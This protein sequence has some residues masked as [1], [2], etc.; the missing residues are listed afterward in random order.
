MAINKQYIRREGIQN[1]HTVGGQDSTTNIYRTEFSGPETNQVVVLAL[2]RGATIAGDITAKPPAD[3]GQFS[4]ATAFYLFAKT[5]ITT[6]VNDNLTTWDTVVTYVEPGP[7]DD[8]SQLQANPLLRPPVFNVEFIETEYPIEQARNLVALP[9]GAA[10]GSNRAVDTLGD[11][12]NAAGK[13]PDEPQMDTERNAVLI[14]ERNYPTLANIVAVNEQFKRSTNSDVVEGFAVETLQYMVTDSQG[15][16]IEGE[17]TYFPG[18]TRI[19][20]KKTTKRIISN[21]GYAFWDDDA[22]KF[23]PGRKEV[24]FEFGPPQIEFQPEI[25]EEWVPIPGGGVWEGKDNIKDLHNLK[26]D[27]TKID[28]DN[29]SPET[30]LEYRYLN[31][32]PYASLIS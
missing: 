15:Q 28:K 6:P 16:R 21:T 24:L 30:F 7:G 29:P 8:G 23:I 14:I 3:G 1:S 5:F 10:D 26:L 18:V 11:L 22:Q 12:T 2:Q 25:I 32:I 20:Q 4:A 13:R 27:G 9:H 19:E 17:Y 31:R